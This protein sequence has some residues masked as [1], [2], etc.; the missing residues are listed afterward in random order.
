MQRRPNVWVWGLAI[1]AI[2]DRL[3]KAHGHRTR[4][5]KPEHRDRSDPP[6]PAQQLR[7]AEQK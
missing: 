1:L 3:Q 4:L 7:T 5:N 6:C 2:H